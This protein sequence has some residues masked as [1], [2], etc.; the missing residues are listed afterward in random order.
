MN[1]DHMKLLTQDVNKKKRNFDKR[2]MVV[3]FQWVQESDSHKYTKGKRA[4]NKITYV[5]GKV[6]DP[7]HRQFF[8]QNS[9]TNENMF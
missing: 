6:M 7:S 3:M 1:Q 5:L 4:A 9:N 8:P 2:N